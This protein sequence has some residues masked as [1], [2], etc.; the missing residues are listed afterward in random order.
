MYTYH[1]EY[2]DKF[3]AEIAA[4]REVSQHADIEEDTVDA[5]HNFGLVEVVREEAHDEPNDSQ[6]KDEQ[7]HFVEDGEVPP[8]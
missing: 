6:N 5:I 2:H 3:W 8:V 4:R 7:V 1:A